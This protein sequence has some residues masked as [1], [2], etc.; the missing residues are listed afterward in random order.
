[1]AGLMDTATGTVFLGDVEDPEAIRISSL[2]AADCT[3]FSADDD[4]ECY[5]GEGRSCFDCR[6][7]RWVPGGFT[8]MRG[9]LGS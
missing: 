8:C 1:M 9:L 2:I 3:G 5:I 4:D 6:A 7:R